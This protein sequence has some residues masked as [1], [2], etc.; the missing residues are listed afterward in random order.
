VWVL[1]NIFEKDRQFLKPGA[2][3]TILYQGRRLKARMT[4]ALP[5]FDAQSRTLKTRFE[6][7]NPDYVLQPDMFVDVELDVEMPPAITVPADAVFDSGLRKTVFV[8]RGSGHFE[9]RRVETGWRLGGRVEIVRGLMEGERVAGAA[10]FLLDSESRMRA[11]AAGIF[12][13]ETDPVCGMEVDRDA[14]GNAKRTATHDGHAYYFCSDD[15]KKKFEADPAKYLAPHDHAPGKAPAEAKVSMT[16][17][18]APK[19]G[20]TPAATMVTDPVCGMEI[21][22]KDAAG[23]AE[24]EGKTYYFCSLDC[25]QKFEKAPLQYIK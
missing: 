15:C 18:P 17:M 25:K 16:G 7:D 19:S 10:N 5:Q 24:Y 3:A 9:A 8:D 14:A 12:N 20:A 1:T 2:E 23:K 6:V 21:D 11:A 4:D 22:P 13:P